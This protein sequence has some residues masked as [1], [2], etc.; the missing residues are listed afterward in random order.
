MTTAAVRRARGEAAG[1]T[2]ES[3]VSAAE[4]VAKR[5]GFDALSLRSV[6]A[7]LGVSPTAIYH[8]VRDKEELLDAV[9]D[10]FIAREVLRRLPHDPPLVRAREIAR[11]MHRAGVE[12]PGLLTALVGYIPE[13]APSAQM[14]VAEELLGCLIAAGAA[15]ERAGL[16]YRLI[17]G[18]CV[19][20][21]V[22]QANYAR[23]HRLPLADRVRA[24]AQL[25]P[26]ASTYLQTIPRPGDQG[27]FEQQLDVVLLE[28]TQ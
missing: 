10:A 19:S 3:V 24:H 18:I 4:T 22:S 2:R 14:E 28:L 5:V 11:R 1:L 17:I 20:S 16:L 7:E 15:P 25:L 23:P 9:A 13:Q 26:L 21:A 12:H 27:V 8:H 6:A